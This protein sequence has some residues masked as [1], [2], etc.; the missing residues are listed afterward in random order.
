MNAVRYR[1]LRIIRHRA[2]S[3]T[4]VMTWSFLFPLG[5]LFFSYLESLAMLLRA[6]WSHGTFVD[7]DE[8][9]FDLKHI[10]TITYH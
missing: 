5:V 3:D 10:Y 1:L 2:T 6:F 4:T 8:N 9:L 7:V